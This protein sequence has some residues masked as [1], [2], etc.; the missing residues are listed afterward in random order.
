M[1]ESLACDHLLREGVDVHQHSVPDVDAAAIDFFDLALH[2]ERGEIGHFGEG[3]AR[4]GMVADLE[5]LRVHPALRVVG[6]VVDD[7]VKGL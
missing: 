7:A 3:S 2:L 4:H 5:G 1:A 6:Q